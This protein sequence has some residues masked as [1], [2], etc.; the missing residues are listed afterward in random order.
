MHTV[1]KRTQIQVGEHPQ[2]L[3]RTQLTHARKHTRMQIDSP[4]LT[5]Q[6]HAIN[7]R[8]PKHTQTARASYRRFTYSPPPPHRRILSPHS[9]FP[10]AFYSWSAHL[11]RICARFTSGV[12]TRNSCTRD[13]A[14]RGPS[15]LRASGEST[16]FIAITC[17]RTGV[18]ALPGGLFALML[19]PSGFVCRPLSSLFILPAS[20][21]LDLLSG[22]PSGDTR[23]GRLRG[24][25]VFT[26]SPV[27]RQRP[28]GLTCT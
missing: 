19:R 23:G 25:C 8:T 24:A 2:S 17:S 21:Y 6:T 5:A 22:W 12:G 18:I 28:C 26:L 7:A 11:P 3:R 14:A 20:L 27:T 10:R 1:N 9:N 16:V 13:W 15:F 4:P